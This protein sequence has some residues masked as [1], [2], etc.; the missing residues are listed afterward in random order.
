MGGSVA[1]LIESKETKRKPELR[2]VVFGK[3]TAVDLPGIS[4]AHTRATDTEALRIHGLMYTPSYTAAILWWPRDRRIGVIRQTH[5]LEEAADLLEAERQVDAALALLL[6]LEDQSKSRS[7]IECY[8]R[9]L[10]RNEK[11]EEALAYLSGADFSFLELVGLFN[12]TLSNSTRPAAIASFWAD[13]MV[14]ARRRGAAAVDPDRKADETLFGLLC[15]SDKRIDRVA[16]LLR[17][18]NGVSIDF[19]ENTLS[20]SELSPNFSPESREEGMIELLRS[21]GDHDRALC[22]IEQSLFIPK[23]W[24]RALSYIENVSDENTISKHLALL[25]QTQDAD[26]AMVVRALVN[27]QLT[28]GSK[29][30]VA[31]EQ[32]SEFT[33]L[34][35]NELWNQ[36]ECVKLDREMQ[37]LFVHSLDR[38]LQS[39]DD[40][41]NQK[42]DKDLK[43]EAYTNMFASLLDSG[44]DDP[45]FAVEKIPNQLWDKRAR[46]LLGLRRYGEVAKVFV[47][48]C[49]NEEMILSFGASL[50]PSESSELVTSVVEEYL[51]K[52][53][54]DPSNALNAVNLLG[55]ALSGEAN[56]AEALQ[57]ADDS[58][59]IAVLHRF[60]VAGMS[61]T[62]GRIKA[63]QSHAALLKAEQLILQ[64]KLFRERAA[65]VSLSPSSSCSI[66]DRR[67]GDSVFASY[68][69]GSKVH[70]ACYMNTSTE[71]AN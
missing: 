3:S 61:I 48:H 62:T 32:D 52:C 58:L 41:A 13:A 37:N 70:Y 53:T 71:T 67:I 27:S 43:C 45:E 10:L 63:A 33:A 44:L 20:K 51:A 8:A 59:Q 24:K 26:M 56:I 54:D 39:I 29:L 9:E 66:C 35:I 55:G 7:L 28:A 31:K 47:E 57:G 1:L 25:T 6:D 23:P 16:A 60:L 49:A 46:L 18:R 2:V 15:M 11:H 38:T 4:L 50:E 21:N 69:D 34:Y 64:N 68:H 65:S 5:S 14:S 36:G 17:A 40:S 42:P 30:A 12:E 22:V 19:G